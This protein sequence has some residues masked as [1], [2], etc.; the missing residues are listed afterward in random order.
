M[1]NVVLVH[2]QIAMCCLFFKFCCLFSSVTAIVKLKQLICYFERQSLKFCPF[3]SNFAWWLKCKVYLDYFGCCLL[4]W[5]H[6]VKSSFFKLWAIKSYS[7]L[8]WLT[9][10]TVLICNLLMFFLCCQECSMITVFVL[11][12]SPFFKFCSVNVVSKNSV[13]YC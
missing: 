3:F 13:I 12:W 8:H 11:L 9:E 6:V 4:Q 10:L 2:F 5:H 1:L 7:L